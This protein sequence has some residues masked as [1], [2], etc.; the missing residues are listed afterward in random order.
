MIKVKKR[1]I[2]TSSYVKGS[3][4]NLPVILSLVVAT[5]FI[6]A[7]ILTSCVQMD[8]KSGLLDSGTESS[9]MVSNGAAYNDSKSVDERISG[10]ESSSLLSPDPNLVQ[11]VLPNGMRYLFA[12]KCNS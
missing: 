9:D 2:E 6:S 7:S 8:K 10:S 1:P 11:G 3:L 4:L 5:M 12:E